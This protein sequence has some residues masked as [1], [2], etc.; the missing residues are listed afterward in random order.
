MKP[1]SHNISVEVLAKIRVIKSS[2]WKELAMQAE[3]TEWLHNALKLSKKE[4]HE[5]ITRE[6]LNY[7]S[8]RE[9]R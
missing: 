1:C 6:H 7:P 2:T 8:L 5:E 3:K 4:D 9:R